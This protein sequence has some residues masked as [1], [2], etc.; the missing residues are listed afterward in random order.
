MLKRL[1]WWPVILVSAM[2]STAQPLLDDQFAPVWATAVVLALGVLCAGTARRLMGIIG[3][4]GSV[5][6]ISLVIVHGLKVN[7]FAGGYVRWTGFEA[8]TNHGALWL[9]LLGSL[10]LLALSA[11]SLRNIITARADR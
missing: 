6:T 7:R 1:I 11:L 10:G 5:A 3:L 9:F 4:F 2:L 8:A